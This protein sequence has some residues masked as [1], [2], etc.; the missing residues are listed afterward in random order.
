MTSEKIESLMRQIAAKH[1][2]EAVAEDFKF[3]IHPVEITRHHEELREFRTHANKPYHNVIATVNPKTRQVLQSRVYWGE[4]APV[5]YNVQQA[6]SRRA[7]LINKIGELA[8]RTLM[9]FGWRPD[10]SAHSI[11]AVHSAHEN[12]KD[13]P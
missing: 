1:E 12:T 10:L 7:K 11:P 8:G 9:L 3:P 5:L 2:V 13:T 4:V 6:N